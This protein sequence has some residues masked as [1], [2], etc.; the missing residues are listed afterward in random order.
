MVEVV[1][2]TGAWRVSVEVELPVKLDLS[3]GEVKV[4]VGTFA[5]DAALSLIVVVV[6]SNGALVGEKRVSVS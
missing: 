6:Q 2:G 4:A 5:D 3:E 1:A